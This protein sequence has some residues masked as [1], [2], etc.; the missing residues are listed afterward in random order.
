MKYPTDHLVIQ[1]GCNIDGNRLC[2]YFVNTYYDYTQTYY[3]V[4]KQQAQE[5]ID[6]RNFMDN[7][8]KVYG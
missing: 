6:Y 2:H 8:L 5:F 3:F 4:N 7:Y 1:K